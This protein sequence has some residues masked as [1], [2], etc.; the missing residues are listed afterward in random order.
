LLTTLFDLASAYSLRGTARDVEYF[1]AQAKQIAEVVGLPLV[2][3]RSEAK[4]GELEGRLR[5]FEAS[6]TRLGNA[7]ALFDGVSHPRGIVQVSR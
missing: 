1:L 7:S 3:A 4:M 5:M 2:V 6:A